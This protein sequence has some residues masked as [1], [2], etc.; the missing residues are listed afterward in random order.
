MLIAFKISGIILQEFR[1]KHGKLEFE[2][3]NFYVW[4]KV[5]S[6][7]HFSELGFCGMH[8]QTSETRS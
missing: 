8:F 2:N 7:N 3:F 6:F 5:T 1:E 4:V